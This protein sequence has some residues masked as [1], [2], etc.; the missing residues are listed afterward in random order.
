MAKKNQSGRLSEQQKIGEGPKTIFSENAKILDVGVGDV[1]KDVYVKLSE[2]YPQLEF[3]YRTEIHKSE[4]NEALHNIDEDLGKTL[5]V[6]NAKIKPD[7]GVIEVKDDSG[8]WR[9]VLVSEAKFQGKD[10]QNIL[11]GTY[12]GKNNDQDLMVAGN[13]I[14]RA[15]KNIWEIANLMLSESHFPYV[16]FLSG[17]NF[18]TKNLIVTRPD[19]RQVLLDAT[20]GALNRL[21]RLSAANYGM[22]FNKN[23]SKNKFVAHEDKA[24]MLQAAS[25]YTK[26][27]GSKWKY[28]EIFE[29]LMDISKTSL[30]MLGRDLFKQIT[31]K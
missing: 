20:S 24:V 27:D 19:G 11:K 25:L 21:D 16:I 3:R 14:E 4:I 13:A 26:G 28:E 1:S 2:E 5:F 10:I 22:E 12:V 30:Q 7:G 29:V 23:L 18:I 8:K 17:S 9:I 6:E 15:H 31:E